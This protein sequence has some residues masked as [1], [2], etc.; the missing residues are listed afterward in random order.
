MTIFLL[1]KYHF[2]NTNSC[3]RIALVATQFCLQKYTDQI[4][5]CETFPFHL[6][7]MEHLIPE[8]HF[9]MTFFVWTV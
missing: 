2:I 1:Q 7:G 5:L 9:V 6:V 4:I 3:Y 8:F